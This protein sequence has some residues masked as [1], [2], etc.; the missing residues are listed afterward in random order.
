MENKVSQNKRYYM[1][2]FEVYCK[3]DSVHKNVL[4]LSMH[5]IV[6]TSRRSSPLRDNF[7]SAMTT[8]RGTTL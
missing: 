7:V 4:L 5:G 6:A 1:R 8:L 3:S 2:E